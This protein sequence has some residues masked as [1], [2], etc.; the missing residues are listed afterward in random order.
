KKAIQQLI[1][2]IEKAENPEEIQSSIFDSAR[3]NALNP[4]DFFKKL[5]QIFLGRDRGP[6]LGPYIWDLGKDRA[7]SI[8]REAISSS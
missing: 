6:R 4:R 3:S 1:Q 7:I 2:A 8:L 5:Y